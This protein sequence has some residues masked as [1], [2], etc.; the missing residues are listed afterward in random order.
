MKGYPVKRAG[1]LAL[2]P[3][4]AAS[5]L[6]AGCGGSSGSST[7]TMSLGVADTPVDTA[8]SVMVAFTGVQLQGASGPATTFTFS[9]PKQIDLM[10]TQ[11]GNAASLLDGVTIPAGNYQWIRLML[12][13]GQSTFTASDGN[14]HALAIPSGVQT[15]LKLVSGFTVAA[16]SQADFTIDFDL[17]KAVTLANGTYMLKP[18]LRLINNQQVGKIAGTAAN[19]FMIGSTAISSPSCSPAVYI[20]S[21]TGVTPVDINDTSTVQPITTATLTLNNTTGDYDYTAAFLAPGDY[22]LAVTC[23]QDDDPIAKDSLVFSAAKNATV[24]ANA[25]TTVDFP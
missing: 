4:M 8:T 6:L 11:S 12:D 1:L 22:T 2:L 18:A 13:I 3:L 19:T 7:A 9:S 25:T 24:T 20:Y 10:T 5:A 15:G 17:R 21:G 16:G 23:A 14:V